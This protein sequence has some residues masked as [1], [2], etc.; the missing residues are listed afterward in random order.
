MRISG[1][2]RYFWPPCG[3]LD[4]PPIRGDPTDTGVAMSAQHDNGESIRC[5]STWRGDAGAFNLLVDTI[6]A[7]RYPM[8]PRIRVLHGIFLARQFEI[9]VRV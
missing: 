1:A 4:V 6:E 7:D 5:S 2:F 9:R 3:N 8:S